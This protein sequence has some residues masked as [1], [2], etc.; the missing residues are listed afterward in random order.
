[1]ILR[2]LLSRVTSKGRVLSGESVEELRLAFKARYHSFKLLL[3]ANNRALEIMSEM[4]EA[5]R[6]TQPF[7]MTFVFSRCTEVATNVWRM[8]KHLDELAPEKYGALYERFK[9]IQL[10][11]NPFI[12]HRIKQEEGPLVIPLESVDIGMVDQVGSKVAN[13]AEIKNRLNRKVADG[14]SITAHAYRTFMAHNDLQT[15]IHRQLQAADTERLDELYRLSSSIQQ[16]IINASLPEELEKAIQDQY[17]ALEKTEEAGVTVAMRSS[18]LGED[19]EGTS[20]AGQYRSELNVSSEHL[21]HAYREVVA[22]KYSIQAMT[23]RL[24]MG[25]R[26]EDVA[27]CVGCMRMVDAVSGGVTYSRNPVDTGDDAVIINAVWGLPKPVVDGSSASDLFIVSRS[28]PMQIRRKEIAHKKEKFVC[29]P[30]EGICRLDGVEEKDDLPSLT[31]GQVLEIARIAVE[32]ESFYGAPQDMEWALESDG[33]IFILQCRPLQ[34]LESLGPSELTWEDE[35]G[36]DRALLNGG[37]TASPGA[38][39]GPVFI[40]KKE[41]DALRFPKGAVLVT[42]QSLPRW[43]SLLDRAAALITEQGSVAGHLANVAREFRVPALFGV[44]GA[45]VLL[46][47]QQVVTVHAD[48]Q[49]VYEGSM[50]GLLQQET[51]TKSMMEGSSVFETLK[52]ASRLIVPLSLLDPDAA[53]FKPENCKTFHDITRFCHEKSMHEMFR[54][55]KRHH[56]M[57]R[58]SKQLVCEV[59]MQWWVLNLDDGF[60]EEV[61]GKHVPLENIVSIPMRALWEGITVIPW[62]GPPAVDGK[63]FASVMFQA[64]TNPALV[65]GV[66]TKYANRNYFMISKNYCSLNSRM[67]FH[68]CVVEALVGDRPGENYLSFQF[69]GGAADHQ[70]RQRRIHFVADI[71]EEHGFRVESREDHLLARVVHGER[72][73]MADRCRIIG[74]L[75]MHTRQLDMVMMAPASVDY[76]RTKIEQDL[77]TVLETGNTK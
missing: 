71:L 54:F 74:Y 69:K 11:I 33:S 42:A 24:N 58:S 34:R 52:G 53:D 55:G 66:R 31:E 73:F 17:H 14:F 62:E 6:G 47:E 61:E 75:L 60:K 20:F 76:Y 38:A 8:I 9:E 77:Q 16:R 4:E 13:V 18:A 7:G 57:E 41:L 1:M 3:S 72:E 12:R 48:G 51:V 40:L 27:M 65:T 70:R 15:E 45:T 59:P 50:D 36:G 56:F 23:Y 35:K 63:G 68:F 22:S 67:G 64:T 28:D 26:D 32:L 43:A 39:A 46:K 49:R 2:R 37:V 19:M 21:L 10:G 29:Y 44:K 25:I 30:D 5:L